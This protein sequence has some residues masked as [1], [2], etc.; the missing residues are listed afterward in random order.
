[1][2]LGLV[3]AVDRKTD[4][5]GEEDMKPKDSTTPKFAA[6]N[7]ALERFF[8]VSGSG[9]G[10]RFYDPV[11]EAQLTIHN[12]VNWVNERIGTDELV[13]WAELAPHN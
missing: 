7:L 5:R 10:M 12:V 3:G 6:I 8:V 1:M 9:Q 4:E 13:G 11:T 2:V